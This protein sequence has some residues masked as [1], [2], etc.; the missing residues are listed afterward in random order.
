MVRSPQKPRSY[1]THDNGQTGYS[2]SVHEADK[3]WENLEKTTTGG[4]RPEVL[5]V[6]TE[7]ETLAGICVF[8]EMGG[9]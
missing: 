5:K 8:S 4:T 3:V 7:Q 6:Q 2:G 9:S 1:R